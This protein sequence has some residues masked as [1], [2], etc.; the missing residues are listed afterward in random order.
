MSILLNSSVGSLSP[1]C[2]K[3]KGSDDDEQHGQS[4]R[5]KFNYYV[6]LEPESPVPS[7][8]DDESIYTV[9][10]NETEFVQDTSDTSTHSWNTDSSDDDISVR[11][12]FEVASHSEEDNPMLNATSSSDPEDIVTMGV[13]AALYN[14]TDMGLADDSD[15][16]RSTVD[17]E[18]GKADYWTCVQCNNK[19]NNP[20]FRYCEK[21]YQIRKNFFPPRPKW[22]RRR[23]KREIGGGVGVGAVPKLPN[24]Q[25]E[26][27]STDSGLGSQESKLSQETE[28]IARLVVPSK[29]TE[30][31]DTVD[32]F[33]GDNLKNE[34]KIESIERIG[35]GNSE[36]RT[37]SV[38]C[39]TD[40][41]LKADLVKKEE[42]DRISDSDNK[43]CLTCTVNPKDGAFSHGKIIHVCCCYQCATRIWREKKICP[44]CNR[45][46]TNVQKVFYN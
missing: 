13:L 33:A 29:A 44:I 37:A 8:E 46:I 38:G 45:K 39:N 4:K 16:S 7:S 3:R 27:T 31:M 12:E 5:T 36:G 26:F 20:L 35:N 24:S 23:P 41:Q 2:L 30:G 6:T 17:S 9:Q 22:K 14:E 15:D 28:E 42:K 10:G 11:L 19:N 43:M 25:D 21:C 18:I 32:Y 40:N 34:I 1:A